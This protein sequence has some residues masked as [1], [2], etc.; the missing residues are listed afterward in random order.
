M[1]KDTIDVSGEKLLPPFRY[2]RSEFNEEIQPLLRLS[3]TAQ[4]W[5]KFISNALS[6]DVGLEESRLTFCPYEYERGGMASISEH[7]FS[8]SSDSS[9]AELG[10]SIDEVLKY[11][12]AKGGRKLNDLITTKKQSKKTEPINE[13]DSVPAA[14]FGYKIRWFLIKTIDTEKVAQ[15]FSLQNIRSSDWATGIDKAYQNSVF[16]SSPVGEWTFVVGWGLSEFIGGAES[17]R[18]KVV[19]LSKVFGEVQYFESH[20]IPDAYGWIK[21]IKGQ[22]IRA[23]FY[24]GERGDNQLVEGNP[25]PVEQ[26]YNLVNTFSDESKDSEYLSREDIVFPDEDLVLRVAE[27]WGVDPM[28]LEERDDIKGQGLLGKIG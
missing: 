25:T 26:P 23:Y 27:S 18:A 8:I 2:S 13:Q 19:E 11:C 14:N 6:F 21:G 3:K 20:R 10:N 7:S 15:E 5:G 16:I 12:V 28:S 24:C 22:I 9:L 4:T 17:I 1:L